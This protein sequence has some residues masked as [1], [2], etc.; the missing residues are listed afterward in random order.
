MPAHVSPEELVLL[1]QV[2]DCLPRP[3]L[4]PIGQRPDKRLKERK[5]LVHGHQWTPELRDQWRARWDKV[6][7]MG[8]A[9][10]VMAKA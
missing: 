3:A 10:E 2:G 8:A 1:D 6:K 9:T 4:K 7:P 5:G